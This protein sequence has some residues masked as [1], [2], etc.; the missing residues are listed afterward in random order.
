MTLILSEWTRVRQIV[1]GGQLRVFYPVVMTTMSAVV[2]GSMALGTGV[3]LLE[4]MSR[5][6]GFL[7]I[8]LTALSALLWIILVFYV[9]S[10][11]PEIIAESKGRNDFLEKERKISDVDQKWPMHMTNL[12][13]EWDTKNSLGIF[14]I[15]LISGLLLFWMLLV[16]GAFALF[17]LSLLG[18]QAFPFQP[19]PTQHHQQF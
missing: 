16:L 15:L 18:Y 3:P 9:N 5:E 10:A 7:A 4:N 11:I 17:C 13:K 2:F 6:S 19:E 12:V 14:A 8:A 1:S